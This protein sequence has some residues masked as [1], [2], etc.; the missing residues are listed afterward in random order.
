MSD[1]DDL[2]SAL[3]RLHDL[4]MATLQNP[5]S[6]RPR[7]YLDALADYAPDAIVLTAED[8]RSD[9]ALADGVDPAMAARRFAARLRGVIL[10]AGAHADT[11]VRE[12]CAL[13]RESVKGEGVADAAIDARAAAA[14]DTC[15]ADL[16]LDVVRLGS[17]G[18]REGAE[19]GA[20]VRRWGVVRSLELNGF[21][22][23]FTRDGTH[24]KAMRATSEGG[25]A[26]ALRFA[27]AVAQA[28]MSLARGEEVRRALETDVARTEAAIAALLA[29]V[30]ATAR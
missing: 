15:R 11:G 29:N 7:A 6:K 27:M 17:L 16:A 10:G 18:P 9:A 13:A 25:D 30:I 8:A 4:A 12:A 26:D 5:A 22:A 3:G 1:V 24:P 19:P 21:V 23:T 20:W 28:A 2:R 14:F